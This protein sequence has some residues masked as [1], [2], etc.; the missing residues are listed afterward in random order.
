MKPLAEALQILQPYG[1]LHV[2]MIDYT[3]MVAY[4]RNVLHTKEYPR[5]TEQ[6]RKVGKLIIY[7]KKT[8]Y[9]YLPTCP[10]MPLTISVPNNVHKSI[11]RSHSR[12]NQTAP[13]REMHVRVITA[14]P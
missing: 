9:V 6:T 11:V 12:Q 8:R 4:M 5:S 10:F 1:V 2:N 3:R 14:E 13:N 7:K